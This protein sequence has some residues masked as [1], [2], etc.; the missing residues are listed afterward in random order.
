MLLRQ[1][2]TKMSGF[3][4]NIDDGLVRFGCQFF[5]TVTHKSQFF[6]FLSSNEFLT[7]FNMELLDFYKIP[8]GLRMLKTETP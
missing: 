4:I 1:N 2:S 8:T 3:C 7:F 5:L 6:I